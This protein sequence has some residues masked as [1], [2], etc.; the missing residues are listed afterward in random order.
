MKQQ[1]FEKT[2]QS[3]WLEFETLL[4]LLEGHSKQ[5]IQNHHKKVLFSQY[6][7]RICHFLAIAKQRN[8]SNYLVEH[9]NDL[10]L[11][12]HQHLYNRQTKA[13]FGVIKFIL[14]EF[15]NA[16]RNNMHFVWV[17]AGFF[18]LPLFIMGLLIYFQPE[19]IYSIMDQARVNEV[20]SMYDPKNQR[21]GFDSRQADD[22][23]MMFGYYIK[24]NISI[25]FQTFASGLFFCL[26]SLFYL[27]FNGVF[28]GGIAGHLTQLGYITPF[29][30]FI[31]GHSALELTAIV[32]AG[33]SGIKIG[34]SLIAPG[35]NSR[36]INLQ[37]SARECIPF[38]YGIT[39]MLTL[40]AFI[41]A[42]WSSK[43][44]L[45]PYLKYG[46]GLTMWI[47]VLIYF[48]LLG[49]SKNATQ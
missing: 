13:G 24:N 32:L 42:F 36:K 16:I 14:H 10:A 15:P 45:D 9:L 1:Q 31:I 11:R 12:G 44:D 38:I 37:N 27:V 43:A 18:Y 20:E 21:I 6:Y 25:G 39:G 49:R 5:S 30:T 4:Q 17:S 7:R 46:F 19:M 34:Y 48:C 35:Q 41:E 22:D 40:A 3:E 26:G 28:I 8:Y 29:Y 2:Y 23:F 47:I 33:A